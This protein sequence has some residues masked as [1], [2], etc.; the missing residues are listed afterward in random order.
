MTKIFTQVVGACEMCGRS[1]F[2][3]PILIVIRRR[4]WIL[5]FGESSEDV[6]RIPMAHIDGLDDYPGQF[7]GHWMRGNR[8]GFLVF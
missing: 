7:Y 1:W 6:M 4:M 2:I 5:W 8:L 3:T